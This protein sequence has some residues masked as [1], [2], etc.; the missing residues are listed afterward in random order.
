MGIFAT[1]V[2]GTEVAVAIAASAVA[3]TEI[4]TA[5]IAVATTV[6]SALTTVA[7]GTTFAFGTCGTLYI[8][9]GFGKE[10]TVRKTELAALL[11]YFK[12]FNLDFVALVEHV[13]NVFDAFPIKI[14]RASC[15]ERV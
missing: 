10:F 12:E 2:A 5:V 15:R 9:F 3:A 4:A 13:F 6:E 7:A 14:R 1:I 11:V 8:A